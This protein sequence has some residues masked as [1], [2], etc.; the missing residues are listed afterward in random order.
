MPKKK[1]KDRPIFKGRSH[2]SFLNQCRLKLVT[3]EESLYFFTQ[4]T[5]LPNGYTLARFDIHLV[6]RLDIEGLVPFSKVSRLNVC[7]ELMRCVNIDRK[8]ELLIFGTYLRS[9]NSTKLF[10]E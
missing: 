5:K 9:P 10:E 6:G 7:T 4:S 8:Q 2:K 1:K 3:L